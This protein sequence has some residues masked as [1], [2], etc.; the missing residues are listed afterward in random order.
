MSS[1]PHIHV[2][3]EGSDAWSGRAPQAR[4]R[5]DGLIDGPLRTLPAALTVAREWRRRGQA[6]PEVRI[7]LAGGRYQLTTPLELGPEDSG[8]TIE[9]APGEEALLDGGT[10]LP[11]PEPTEDA[12]GPLWRI[13][14]TDTLLHN[15]PFNSLFAGDERRPQSRFPVDDYLR[16]KDAPERFPGIEQNVA[17]VQGVRRFTTDPE[18]LRRFGDLRGVRLILLNRWLI[19]RV[20]VEDWDPET[21][22]FT[23]DRPTRLFLRPESG[24][25]G[26]GCRFYLEDLPGAPEA[27]GTWTQDTENGELLYRPLP[28]ERPE[29]A[30]L[31][32]P[33]IQQFVRVMGELDGE[34]VRGI[35]LK[36]LRFRHADW[37]EPDNRFLWWDPYRPE[38]EWKPRGSCRTFVETNGAD[39]RQDTGSMPQAAFNCPGTIQFEAA[40]DCA[41]VDCEIAHVGFYAVAAWRG[42]RNLRFQGNHW[43]DLGAGGVL[44]EGGEFEES[45]HHATGH[46]NILDNTIEGTGHVFPAACGIALLHAARCTLAHNHIHDLSYSGISVGWIWAYTENPSF[47]HCIEKNHIH[48]VGARGGLSDMGAIYL[49]GFQPG[50][51]IRHNYIHDVNR[52]AYG[53]WGI[54]PDEGSSG[55]TIQGNLVVRCA[56]EC[57]H[58]HFGRQNIYLNNVF[59]YGEEGIFRIARDMRGAAYDFPPQGTLLLRNIFLGRGAPMF[60]DI[61]A[62]IRGPFS[63]ISD[64]NLFWDE[65][66]GENLVMLHEKRR[67]PDDCGS[68]KVV[69]EKIGVDDY[70][71]PG[72]DGHSA[73]VDPGFTDPANEDYALSED[74]PARAMGIQP[75]ELDDVGPRKC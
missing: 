68:E 2:S 19:E 61:L 20:R 38:S 56:S 22:T 31:T 26:G 48:D 5:A 7:R 33:V 70:R 63:V 57:V 39:P 30:E 6:G 35:T 12:G 34:S 75:L 43:R 14:V 9:G 29:S 4:S 50:T 53:G 42:C 24:L 37:S 25:T 65:S 52:A 17:L 36:N 13:D 72:R 69:E 73:V 3:T 66:D 46:L 49:L 44:A 54:Y 58:Q 71:Q 41:V 28:G 32:V 18:P 27:P 45:G 16:V 15:G 23:L 40:S 8:I 51:Q 1:S 10:A 11:A 60:L 47:G 74:S 64:A 62:S 67:E 21:G 59:A 55:L